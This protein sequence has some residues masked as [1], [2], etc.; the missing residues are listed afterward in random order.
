MG[1]LPEASWASTLEGREGERARWVWGG[2]VDLGS[3]GEE[4]R[5]GGVAVWVL[6]GSPG[7]LS[8]WFAGI[9]KA[10]IRLSAPFFLRETERQLF[11]GDLKH[12]SFQRE[13]SQGP[14][15]LP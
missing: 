4:G 14:A 12:R 9:P 15:C 5:R 11:F 8:Y 13:K 1:R 6:C 3:G 7:G 10:G 2:R